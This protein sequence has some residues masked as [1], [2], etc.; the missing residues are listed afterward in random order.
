MVA[1]TA[2]W[3]IWKRLHQRYRGVSHRCVALVVAHQLHR[4]QH[5]DQWNSRDQ[6]LYRHM[7]LLHVGWT[8]FRTLQR[9]SKALNE[10]LIP[11]ARGSTVWKAAGCQPPYARQR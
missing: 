7:E 8:V 6:F 2:I 3:E 10:S 1:R 9:I 5:T 11:Q 4:F